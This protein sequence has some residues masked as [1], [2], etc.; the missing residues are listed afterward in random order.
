[1]INEYPM[2]V[3]FYTDVRHVSAMIYSYPIELGVAPND[4]VCPD[5]RYIL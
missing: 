1:M 5:F 3:N 4:A 2:D